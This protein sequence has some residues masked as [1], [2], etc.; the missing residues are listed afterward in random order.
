MLPPDRRDL[1]EKG[2]EDLRVVRGV[3]PEMVERVFCASAPFSKKTVP[4]G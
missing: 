3:H 2:V 4:E 1:V